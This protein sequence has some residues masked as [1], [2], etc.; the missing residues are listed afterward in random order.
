METDLSE[1]LKVAPPEGWDDFAS[2]IALPVLEALAFA[3]SRN[4]VHRDLKPSNI[5]I[6][7]DGRP[8]LADFG[9]SK[10]KRW[11]QPGITLREWV[12]RPYAPPG[13]DDGSYTRDV[14]SFAVVVLACLTNV[15]LV[16]YDSVAKAQQKIDAPPDIK[17]ILD[18][19]LSDDPA[20][21][22]PNAN[23][24]L[25]EIQAVQEKRD[26]KHRPRRIC[27][28]E[29]SPKSMAALRTET[30][31]DSDEAVQSILMD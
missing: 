9:I 22:Q 19:A 8:R 24:L 1:R 10:W 7:R 20:E 29:L 13:E 23:I 18:R 16:D 17:A 3:H 26:R 2:A 15:D 30:E 14:Y 5:L 12:S 6:D 28:L 21:R 27:F 11:L 4:V 25:A 31:L